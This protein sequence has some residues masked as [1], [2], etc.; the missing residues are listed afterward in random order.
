[1]AKTLYEKV[2]DA[3]VV[4]HN[5]GELPT[6]FVDRHLIHEVTSPQAFS[7]LDLAGRKVRRPDLT[8]ATMDHDVSTKTQ[9][10][11]ACSAMARAQIETLIDNT[12]KHDVTLFALGDDNQ[13]IVHIIGPQ[14]GFTLPGTTLVCGDSHT[15]THGAFGAL[16]F[17][18]GTSEVEHVLAT[19]TIKQGRLKTMLIKCN[20]S[21]QKGVYAK[22]LILYII[23]RLT[24]AGGTGY[25]VEFAGQAIDELSMEGRMTLS[26]MAIEFGAKAGMIAP[27]KTTFE[28]LK[29]RMY[30]PKGEEFDKACAAWSQLKS[31]EDAV[32]DK[33]VEIDAS[34]IEPQVT[35]GTNPGQVCAITQN[36][37]Y[38]SDF[39]DD[40][41]KKSLL[42]ALSYIDLKQGQ[43]L[44]EAK[45]DLVFIGSCTNGRIE[46]FREAARVLKGRKIDPHVTA[47]A[48]PGSMWVK[49]QA[50]SEG[51]DVIFK[52]AGFEWRLPGCSMCLAMNDDKAPEG[53]RVASTSNRNFV[54]RQGKGARTH[55]MSPA[56]AAACAIKG[57]IADVREYL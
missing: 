16:A 46:D 35:Y 5:E 18:I 12:K 51:L 40:V 21:L 25:C 42:D 47:L 53:S 22:D 14:V 54:G 37:P 28:Y 23:G 33:V 10:L 31:D 45:V 32:F 39:S 9:S 29:N 17:G 2:F 27:D 15:A 43:S 8:L 36:V 56:T 7:G 4:F 52:D 49:K 41:V 30:A 6:L 20:G 38:E 48:V 24:T 11:D 55:L 1:M 3:H 57:Y 13:G 44:T 34:I 19:Q 26:N 50:E